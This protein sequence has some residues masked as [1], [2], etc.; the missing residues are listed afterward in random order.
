VPT[1]STPQAMVGTLR[2]AHPT[3]PP[4]APHVPFGI[5][6]TRHVVVA[7]ASRRHLASV[8]RASAVGGTA[9]DAERRAPAAHRAGILRHALDEGDLEFE[10]G[11]AGAVGKRGVN[12][13]SHRGIP[14]DRGIAAVHRADRIVVPK[15]RH[16]CG[17]AGLSFM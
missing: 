9:A 10:R 14:Q 3:K 15:A 4:S 16:G 8:I 7:C 2:F 11:V 6:K 13:K 1:I 12:G 5:S 17:P